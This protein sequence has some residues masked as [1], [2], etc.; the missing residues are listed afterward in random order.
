MEVIRYSAEDRTPY[1]FFD[2][3]KGIL[4]IEG[5]CVPEDAKQFFKELQK[6]LDIYG[7][8]PS[9]NLD[10]TINLEYFN[11]ATAKEL[12]AMMYKFKNFPTTVTW[13]HE[14][15]DQDMIDVG[16][17]FEEILGTVPFIFKEVER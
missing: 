9:K 15:K 11:T 3:D 8:T 1:V 16:K 12:M 17:D 7:E 5:R 4:D 2:G 14:L 6:Q 13:C 10:V